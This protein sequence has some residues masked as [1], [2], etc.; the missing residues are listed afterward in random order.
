M[1]AENEL[2]L[3]AIGDRFAVV[4]RACGN[5][6]A[7]S[8]GEVGFVAIADTYEA[9]VIA[10]RNACDE[11]HSDHVPTEYGSPYAGGALPTAE[12]LRREQPRFVLLLPG[13]RVFDMYD[14]Q[15]AQDEE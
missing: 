3:C 6:V 14:E 7:E 8:Y 12:E 13:D 5:T 2:R 9:A 10:F 11:D 15:R 1:S 4:E